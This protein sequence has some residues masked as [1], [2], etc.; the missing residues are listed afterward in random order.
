MVMFP[1]RVVSFPARGVDGAMQEQTGILHLPE[2]PPP[3]GGYPVVVYGHMTTG[4]GPRSAPSGGGS[5]HPEQRRMSQGDALCADL[6]ARGLAVLR[7]DYEGIGSPG[8][9]PYL[10]GSSLAESMLAM[11]R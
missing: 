3:A 1:G 4:G 5:D 10:I 9:H 2:A 11:M 7:P 8:V 6:V